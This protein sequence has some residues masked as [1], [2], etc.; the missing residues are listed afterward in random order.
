MAQALQ[1]PGSNSVLAAHPSLT[2]RQGPY[3]W[4]VVTKNG[5]SIYSVTKG[6][7]TISLPIRWAFGAHAQTWVFERQGRFYQSDVSFYPEKDGLRTTIGETYP[8]PHNLDEAIGNRL[9]PLV[10]R[11]CFACHS[12]NGVSKR[13]H[14][15]LATL[16]PGVSCSRC[17]QGALRHAEYASLGSDAVNPPNLSALSSEEMASFCGQC[18]RTF[19]TVIRHRWRGVIDVR[20]QP[21]RLELSQ[22]FNGTDP[23][24]SCVACH[25][26]HK[27]LVT[28][29]VWYDKKCLACHA[30]GARPTST[31]QAKVCPVS[32]SHCV[33]CHMPRVTLPGSHTQFTDHFIRIVKPGAPYPD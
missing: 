2:W 12:T 32:T 17:H 6:K 15:T 25:D 20:F 21:Y 24:I 13:Q 16:H 28:S 4:T 5:Q 30:P 1:L 18:H 7:E 33:R 29:L 23:R 3:T 9:S 10:T 19:S 31:G 14:L 11:E 27:P 22:C 8:M 26:P